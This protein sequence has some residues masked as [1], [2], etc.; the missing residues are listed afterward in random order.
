MRMTPPSRPS[1]P[2]IR[3]TPLPAHPATAVGGHLY[4]STEFPTLSGRILGL[5]PPAEVGGQPFCVQQTSQRHTDRVCVSNRAKGAVMTSL[6]EENNHEPNKIA[7]AAGLDH[8]IVPLTPGRSL[9]RLP[10]LPLWGL[11]RLRVVGGWL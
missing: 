1:H 5:E 4:D 11:R 7:A 8:R 6:R 3:C 10:Q 2:R 9:G